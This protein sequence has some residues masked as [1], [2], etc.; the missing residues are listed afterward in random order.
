MK[1]W[2]YLILGLIFAGI[3]AFIIFYRSGEVPKGSQQT[4]G[5]KEQFCGMGVGQSKE[6]FCG[7][8]LSD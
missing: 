2:G 1:P 3:I 5:G 4:Q 7:M 8:H 6:Q